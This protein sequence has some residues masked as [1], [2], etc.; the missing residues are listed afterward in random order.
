MLLHGSF[1]RFVNCTNGTKS[2]NASHISK[3][4]LISWKNYAP[5]CGLQYR[6]FF[7][8]VRECCRLVYSKKCNINKKKSSTVYD[9]GI[10]ALSIDPIGT[11]V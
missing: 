7:L 8:K 3:N 2:C 5:V 4:T 10:E 6:F 9:I 1:S 11:P